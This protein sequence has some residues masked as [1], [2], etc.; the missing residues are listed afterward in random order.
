MRDL[1]QNQT[2][3]PMENHSDHFPDGDTRLQGPDMQ[4]RSAQV[5]YSGGYTVGDFLRWGRVDN[6]LVT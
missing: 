5:P 3:T 6:G 1:P 4:V 2:Q